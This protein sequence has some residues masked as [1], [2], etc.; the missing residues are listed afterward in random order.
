MPDFR[1]P[2][3]PPQQL[4]DYALGKL[5]AP[6]RSVIHQ[7]LAGCPD[8]RQK[9][10]QQ[11]LSSSVGT[12]RAANRPAA[13][14][15]PTAAYQQPSIL[16]AE[17]P[18]ASATLP[19]LPP[20]L[21]SCSKFQVLSKLGEGG[22]GAV[23]KAQHTFLGE[24][25][26]IK[27]MK[28]GALATPQARSRFLREMKAAGQL[29]HPNIVRALDAEQMGDLLVLVME[30]VPGITLDRLVKQRGPL[31]VDFACRCI[32]QAAQ[33]LQ[34]AH[35][36]GMVHR[37]IKPGNMIVTPQEQEVKLL[38]F[39]L[40]RGTRE[41]A[42]TYRTQIGAVMGTPAYMAPEQTTDASSADIRADIYSLGCTLY[43]LLAGKSPFLR[44][45]LV[46][47]M[48]AQVEE[49]A[50]PVTEVRT[51]VPAGL[52]AVLAKMLAKKPENRYQTPK[53]VEEALRPFVAGQ[54]R[55]APP[56]AVQAPAVV[57]A[58]TLLMGDTR[59]LKPLPPP[60]VARPVLPAQ[61]SSPFDL[62]A[63]LP[64]IE[65]ARAP[66]RKKASPARK[67]IWVACIAAGLLATVL[68]GTVVLMLTMAGED[69][70][71]VHIDQP[72]AEVFVDGK[73]MS[74]R[75]PGEMKPIQVPVAEGKHTLRVSKD[76]FVAYTEYFDHRK[77]EGKP[78]QVRLKSLP[79]E[80][81]PRPQSEIEKARAQLEKSRAQAR[82]KLLSDF[83]AT[84]T[85]LGKG[86]LIEVVKAE[87]KRFEKSRLV[88]WS[89]PM[90]PYMLAYLF[91]LRA[92][93]QTAGHA[94]TAEIA[95]QV[96]SKNDQQAADLR[97]EWKAVQDGEVV[98]RWRHHWPAGNAV[99]ILYANGKIGKPEGADTWKF[100]NGVLTL[101]WPN[102]RVP[103][104]MFVDT[105]PVSQ[106]GKVY[107]GTNQFRARISGDCLDAN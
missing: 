37:D 14:L 83:D 15:P 73:K 87:K 31:P 54:A 44:D 19:D 90:R 57:E 30:H 40:A 85:R 103:G 105:C 52:W 17:P 29:K 92:A 100:E 94:Y 66:K 79:K 64:T 96:E 4:S 65:R 3:P 36:K 98:A 62:P 104:G 74:I 13:A 28:A 106:D 25:V 81:P 11:T 47:T 99:I 61:D 63:T 84:I 24:L 101:L 43:F 50:R 53:E 72:D 23:Y 20:E 5:S 7:H 59:E 41:T 8:C 70:V 97:A 82:N 39:G 76:G 2:C 35:E 95:S 68:F 9:V 58:A 69:K 75:V 42:R 107:S 46:S 48:L 78:I 89:A 71:V 102:P 18:L 93:L 6:D 34:H 10:A 67:T 60:P 1:T 86:A 45:S 27:V 80:P 51:D 21:A 16:P 12:P 88:P 77:G 22:V 55:K 91:S 32:A 38:D 26:A 33:G 56:G 49:E